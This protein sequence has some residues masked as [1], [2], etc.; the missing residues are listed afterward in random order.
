[1]TFIHGY[2]LGGLC[3]RACRCCCTCSC[4]R[5]PTPELPRVSL[6]QGE[7]AHQPR[8]I[9]LQ[10]LLLL[11]LRMAV[12]ARC[13]WRWPGRASSPTAPAT[14]PAAPSS[15]RAHRHQRQHGLRRLRRHPARRSARPGR[16]LLDE[17]A[18]GSRVALLDS[19]DDVP[20]V[21]LPRAEV[22]TRL[23]ALRIRPAAGSLNLSVERAL[24]CSNRPTPTRGRPGCSTSSPTAPA[25]PGMRPARSRRCPRG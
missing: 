14:P 15:P 25:P 6:P 13:V 17:M 4:A 5:S 9:R 23:D 8:K 7:A 18:D 3:S 11:L 2:L 22:R 1:M 16:E 21:F 10:H 20:P 19:G 12:V 24:R